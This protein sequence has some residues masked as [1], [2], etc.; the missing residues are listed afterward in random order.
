MTGPSIK[1]HTAR[2]RAAFSKSD[3]SHQLPKDTYTPQSN[4]H[5]LNPPANE[6]PSNNSESIQYCESISITLN[7]LDQSLRL[8]S[9]V[10]GRRIH[11]LI[12]DLHLSLVSILLAPDAPGP[13]AKSGVGKD[14]VCLCEVGF[15]VLDEGIGVD[16]E[17]FLGRFVKEVEPSLT[18]MIVD[19]DRHD[20]TAPLT[21]RKS[22]G[23]G[24]LIPMKRRIPRLVA[25][26]T[27]PL[28]TPIVDNL[29]L[30]PVCPTSWITYIL[31]PNK[32]HRR[33]TRKILGRL[34]HPNLLI[35]DLSQRLAH[36]NPPALAALA[37]KRSMRHEGFGAPDVFVPS[38]E[39]VGFVEVGVDLHHGGGEEGERAA[40]KVGDFGSFDGDDGFRG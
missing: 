40:V 5:L 30:T 21:M 11:N 25:T 22:G 10:D 24:D 33:Q 28:S 36:I 19:R 35:L 39:R 9:I 23:L 13:R 20:I 27:T 14:F 29:F 15:L 3:S 26:F 2:L 38:G 16:S 37:T 6:I 8:L 1:Y 34:P 7:N 32:H 18:S 31:L 12:P 17:E 4:A